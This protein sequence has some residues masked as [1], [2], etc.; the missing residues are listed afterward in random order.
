M[1]CS[2]GGHFTE[3]QSLSSIFQRYACFWVTYRSDWLNNS[4]SYLLKHYGEGPL[5][6]SVT[7]VLATLDALLILIKEKPRLIISTGSEIALPFLYLGKLLGA[8]IVY[9]ESFTRVSTPSMTGKF[10]YPLADLFLVQ[11]RSLLDKYGKRAL[12]CGRVV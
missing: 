6:L 4:N 2:A 7:L 5:N 10:A 8:K 11:W 12:Y 1:V 9:I 3:L